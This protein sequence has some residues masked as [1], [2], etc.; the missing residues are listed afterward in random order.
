MKSVGG[1]LY[2]NQSGTKMA[3]I[4]ILFS[5]GIQINKALCSY[6]WVI[7]MTACS[8]LSYFSLAGSCAK[9]I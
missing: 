8:E 4:R 5:V 3:L 7:E 6:K 9:F 1:K 2:L